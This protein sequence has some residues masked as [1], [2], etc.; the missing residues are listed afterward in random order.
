MKKSEN[1]DADHLLFSFS[2]CISFHLRISAKKFLEFI[3]LFFSKRAPTAYRPSLSFRFET[4]E[5]N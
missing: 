3:R 4:Q 1:T 2:N 5:G